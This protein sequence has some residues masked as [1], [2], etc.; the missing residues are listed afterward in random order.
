V[1][2]ASISRNF[3]TFS[4]FVQAGGDGQLYEALADYC[5]FNPNAPQMCGP[6]TPTNG[7]VNYNWSVGTSNIV[8]LSQAS[9]QFV[10]MPTLHGVSAGTG[11]ANVQ[12]TAGQCS[13]G[14]GGKPTTQVPTSLKLAKSP[15]ILQTGTGA[16]HGCPPGWYGTMIDVDYQV[17]DQNTTPIQNATMEPQENVPGL[18]NGFQDIGA[19]NAT[20]RKRQ[21]SQDRTAHSMMSL[22]EIA[23][24]YL[25]LP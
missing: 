17:L 1:C 7:L 12:V 5:N 25:S 10:K 23:H 20:I 16:Q 18:T 14:G 24:R 8:G 22:L 4:S 13:S 11:Y 9:Q 3:E 21:N 2:A 19:P 6:G 15:T